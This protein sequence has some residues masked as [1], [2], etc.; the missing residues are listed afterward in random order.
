MLQPAPPPS[1][2]TAYPTWGSSANA[3]PRLCPRAP[4]A[5][6]PEGTQSSHSG[7]RRKGQQAPFPK[8]KVVNAEVSSEIPQWLRNMPWKESSLAHG[9]GN[10]ALP[11]HPTLKH[12]GGH[13][14]CSPAPTPTKAGS[15]LA[16]PRWGLWEVSKGGKEE[17]KE[18]GGLS[19]WKEALVD[20]WMLGGWAGGW[21]NGWVGGKKEGRMGGRERGRMAR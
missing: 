20:E 2:P 21:M 14:P 8:G 7:Q 11:L 13:P 1:S 5:G 4:C 10:W 18:E 19:R 17:I 12:T 6:H 9:A 16:Q 15:P 3:G